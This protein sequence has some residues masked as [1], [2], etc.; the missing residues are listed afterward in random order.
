MSRIYILQHKQLVIQF[1]YLLT[2]TST[3]SHVHF[4]AVLRHD[5]AIVV[6]APVIFALNKTKYISD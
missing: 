4:D 3:S 5:D 2:S 6:L 1:N